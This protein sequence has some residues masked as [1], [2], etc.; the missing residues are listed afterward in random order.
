MAWP[1]ILGR[2]PANESF[3]RVN[4]VP[5]TRLAD[6]LGEQLRVN[7]VAKVLELCLVAV[8]G[9][10]FVQW[11]GSR[12][13]DELLLN[14]LII[15]I[16]N[17]MMMG[18]IGLGL[19]FRGESISSI[20]LSINRGTAKQVAKVFLQSLL[21]FF[22]AMLGFM[23]GSTIMVNITGVPEAADMTGYD[24]LKDNIG[25]LVLSLAGVYIVSS[26]GEEIIYRYFLITRISQLGLNGKVGNTIAVI[27]SA[28]IFGL[29]HYQWGLLGIVQTV[30]MGLALGIC[31]L[32]MKRKLWILIL[33]HAY[34]DTILLVQVYLSLNA[35]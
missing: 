31:Y 2:P 25:M 28:L 34:M 10:C 4:L 1:Y 17:V 20:D 22:L 8:I 24:Y 26:I 18:V 3:G 12:P 21:V 9:L 5:M 32:R 19:Y 14:Q 27:S 15:W 13:K 7:R 23:I 30:F 16:A 35:K 29:A 6:K 11:V 33:A